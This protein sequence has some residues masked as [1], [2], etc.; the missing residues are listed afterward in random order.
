MPAS[1]PHRLRC[2]REAG[3]S[4][5]SA[6]SLS[7]NHQGPTDPTCIHTCGTEMLIFTQ[8]RVWRGPNKQNG[9]VDARRLPFRER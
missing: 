5:I 4:S 1:W 6:A 9:Y 3:S 8:K 7:I 2:S